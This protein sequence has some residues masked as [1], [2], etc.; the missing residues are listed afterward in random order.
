M[1]TKRYVEAMLIFILGFETKENFLKW[2][3]GRGT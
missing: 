2:K 1:K 3:H